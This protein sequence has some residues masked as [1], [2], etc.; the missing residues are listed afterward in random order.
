MSRLSRIKNPNLL[1][2]SIAAAPWA[3]SYILSSLDVLNSLGTTAF[4]FTA[5]PKLGF[6]TSQ[7]GLADRSPCLIIVSYI[8]TVP[9]VLSLV[10]HCYIRHA[11]PPPRAYR[12][13][14]GDSSVL[15]T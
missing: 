11:S 1:C 7:L 2:P 8:L 10:N 15:T 13:C 6:T 5:Y 14:R 9:C 4:F 3:Y 12:R